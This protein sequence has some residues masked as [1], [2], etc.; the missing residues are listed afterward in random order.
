MGGGET[1]DLEEREEDDEED[2][3]L[4]G[5]ISGH[6]AMMGVRGRKEMCR[7]ALGPNGD[8]LYRGS[9]SLHG[10]FSIQYLYHINTSHCTLY[11]THRAGMGHEQM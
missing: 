1:S 2:G 5:K 9:S 3:Y 10:K 6:D 8:P 11:R 7:S 4:A